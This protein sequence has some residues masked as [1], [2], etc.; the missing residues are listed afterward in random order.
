LEQ[1]GTTVYDPMGGVRSQTDG[2]NN[3]SITG[4][5]SVE[6]P[7]STS[8]GQI[9]ASSVDSSVT[10]HNLPQS[11]TLTRSYV[12]YATWPS[13]SIEYYFSDSGTGGTSGLNSYGG[14][15]GNMSFT[16]I[17]ASNGPLGNGWYELG[18]LS[19]DAADLTSEVT[20]TTHTAT[21][22]SK[23][24]YA[25]DPFGEMVARTNVNAGSTESFVYDGENIAL[26]LNSSGGVIE[27]ELDGPAVD[28][29]LASEAG[30][31]TTSSSFTAGMVDWYL[32]DNKGSVRDVV[33]L[34]GGGTVVKDHI[35]YDTFG[36][37]SSQT[38]S[39]FAPTVMYAGMYLDPITGL[40]YDN[41]RWYDAVFASQD[42]AG[43]EGGPNGFGGGQTNT[44]E[45]CG[46][47][48]SNGTDPTGEVTYL[49]YEEMWNIAKMS[50][51][52]TD[53]QKASDQQLI[54][55]YEAYYGKSVDRRRWE[56]NQELEYTKSDPNWEHDGQTGNDKNYNGVN[57]RV[58]ALD[59]IRQEIDQCNRYSIAAV[60]VGTLNWPSGGGTPIREE[61]SAPGDRS[62]PVLGTAVPGRTRP[63]ANWPDPPD[64]WEWD[65]GSGRYKKG[66]RYRHWHEDEHHTG[67]WDEEDK[68]G[69]SHVN[70]YES[71]RVVGWGVIIVG[72]GWGAWELGKW[73]SAVFFAP[74]TF[75]GSLAGAAALP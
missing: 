51:P 15:Y 57:H 14:T 4:L 37:V 65:K 36:Q 33:Q 66:G 11:P 12:I 72:A 71:A 45:Y 47:S 2:L 60:G 48:P 40:Y 10:F 8:Q 6:E 59:A 7:V 20:V 64:G 3:V 75:G 55:A 29:V 41:A 52:P 38:N 44:E 5:D 32:A 9:L 22:E 53:A 27:R 49:S 21:G 24:D 13:G 69:N 63:P 74:E 62:D 23:I 54:A 17:G 50:P 1:T 67:H 42:P 34:S 68:N 28:Q 43:L 18:I 46:N 70:V 61:P 19:L 16:P 73:G 30:A 31:A 39:A 35:D 26:I 58:Y 56:L 25:N